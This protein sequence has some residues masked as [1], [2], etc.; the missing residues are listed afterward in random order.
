[1][2]NIFKNFIIF[3]RT[4]GFV[5]GLLRLQMQHFLPPRPS[6]FPPP[7]S[8]DHQSTRTRVPGHPG[9]TRVCPGIAAPVISH[10]ALSAVQ[11]I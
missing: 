7:R 1:M 4:S 2:F 3:F 6:V 8:G 10:K 11:N 9:R 5:S